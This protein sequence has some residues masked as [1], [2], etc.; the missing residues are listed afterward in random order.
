MG[1]DL[2]LNQFGPLL[3]QKLCEGAQDHHEAVGIVGGGHGDDIQ[4]E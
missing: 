4:V 3:F 1:K 2:L